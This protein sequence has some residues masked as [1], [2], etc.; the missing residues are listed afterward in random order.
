MGVQPGIL[1]NQRPA[2]RERERERERP[3]VSSP[4]E[5]PSRADRPP[6]RS[7]PAAEIPKQDP[8]GTPEGSAAGTPPRNLLVLIQHEEESMNL[9]LSELDRE[10]RELCRSATSRRR[11]RRWIETEPL[12][13]GMPTLKASSTSGGTT[14]RPRRHP[15]RA[16]PV[17]RHPRPGGPHPAPGARAGLV[18]MA[19]TTCSDDPSAIEEFVSLAWERIRTYP[20]SRPGPVAANVL[21]DVRKRYRE[22]RAIEAPD[23]VRPD[24]PPGGSSPRQRTSSSAAPPSATSSPPN[25]TVSST[26]SPSGS[27]CGPG[28][29]ASR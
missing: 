19:P 18:R 12:L 26:A 2:G 21:M 28:S 27:S 25:E 1:R 15:G 13:A 24:L 11:W 14:P 23:G 5:Q 22:H 29:T 10:W 16:R 20:T 6:S 17:R 9:T 7:H 8:D 3:A 4:C